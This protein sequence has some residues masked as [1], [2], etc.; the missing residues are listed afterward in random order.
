MKTNHLTSVLI[1]FSLLAWLAFTSV[2]TKPVESVDEFERVDDIPDIA[3]EYNE[4]RQNRYVRVFD[5]EVEPNTRYTQLDFNYRYTSF[6]IE[7]FEMQPLQNVRF[8][9]SSGKVSEMNGAYLTDDDQHIRSEFIVPDEEQSTMDLYTGTLQ[10]KIR[11]YLFYAPE[12]ELNIPN[13]LSKS[14]DS[15]ERPT[16]IPASEWRKGL[17]DPVGERESTTVEHVIVHHAASSNDNHDY[18]SVIRNIYLLHTQ[19]NGWDDIGYN[20]VVAQDGTVFEG[21]DNQGVAD[22]DNIKGA[23][24]CGKNSGTMGVC[25]LGNYMETSPTTNALFSL[26]HLIRWKCGK[27]NINPITSSHHPSSSD[28]LLPHVAGHRDG[29]PTACPGDSLYPFVAQIRESINPGWKDCYQY[30]DVQKPMPN[31]RRFRLIRIHD[32]I[33]VDSDLEWEMAS[34]YNLNGQLVGELTPSSNS[35]DQPSGVYIIRLHLSH[36]DVLTQRFAF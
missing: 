11:I 16:L 24:F 36:G 10:G 4:A 12:L 23:H 1:V 35:F 25:M 17:P 33:Q 26:K 2:E 20:F 18:V 22:T 28:P 27:S 14:V 6:I 29:C 13:R 30:L 9:S 8:T 5:L 15:C 31:E 32:H 19:S 3:V 34:V 7:L 21:R